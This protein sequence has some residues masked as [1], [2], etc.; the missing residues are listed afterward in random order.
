M[1]YNSHQ[2]LLELF[3]HGELQFVLELYVAHFKLLV[4]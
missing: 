3:L 1:R 4:I 2:F